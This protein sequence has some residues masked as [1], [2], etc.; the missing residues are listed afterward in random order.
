MC[1]RYGLQEASSPGHPPPWSVECCTQTRERR[2]RG[3]LQFQP[4]CAFCPVRDKEGGWVSVL[5]GLA[6]TQPN[7][8]QHH[9]ERSCAAQ[10]GAR[11]ALRRAAYPGRRG[12]CAPRGAAGRVRLQ[13]RGA[14]PRA[15]GCSLDHSDRAPGAVV[16]AA[17]AAGQVHAVRAA[18][19]VYEHHAAVA[20]RVVAAPHRGDVLE[21]LGG[22]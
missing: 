22:C 17:R 11:R 18:G 13:R 5:T 2:V 8:N 7:R 21:G 15:G 6:Q 12:G 20:P 1:V 19:R 14:Y 16:V 10:G 4:G 3:G 9:R